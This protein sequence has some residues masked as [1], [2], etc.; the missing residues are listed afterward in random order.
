MIVFVILL[1][2]VNILCI[3]IG[4]ER[5]KSKPKSSVWLIVLST[6]SI[7]LNIIHLINLLL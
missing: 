1:M 7:T 5:L 6:V 2:F 4:I 3:N